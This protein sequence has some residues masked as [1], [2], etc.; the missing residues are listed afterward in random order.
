M[1]AFVEHQPDM[2]LILDNRID[3]AG[4]ARDMDIQLDAR[5]ALGEF[6]QGRSHQV[7]DKAFAHGE[8]NRSGFQALVGFE[9]RDEAFVEGAAPLAVLQ[10][11]LADGRGA[12]AAALAFHEG[13][14]Q[15]CFQ[16]HYPIC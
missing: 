12:Y 14:S 15:G 13:C 3:D 10:Q 4:C 9:G 16:Q 2:A 7:A 11:H 1:S 6:M 5:I 8:G